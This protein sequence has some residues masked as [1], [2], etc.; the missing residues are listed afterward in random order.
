MGCHLNPKK[1]K[2]VQSRTITYLMYLFDVEYPDSH[3]E[4]G[5]EANLGN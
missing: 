4:Q 3:N 1:S 5:M 2:L